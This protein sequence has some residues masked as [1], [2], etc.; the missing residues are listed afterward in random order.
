M[1]GSLQPDVVYV[2][3]GSPGTFDQNTPPPT[4]GTIDTLTVS[5]NFVFDGVGLAGNYTKNSGNITLLNGAGSGGGTFDNQGGITGS[6]DVVADTLDNSGAIDITGPVQAGT[7]DNHGQITT[8]GTANDVSASYELTNTGGINSGGAIQAAT[9]LISSGSLEASLDISAGSATLTGGSVQARDFFA[10]QATIESGNVTIKNW[11]SAATLD[12]VSGSIDSAG[13]L[14]ADA[15][16]MSASASAQDFFVSN[17]IMDG[18]LSATDG[19]DFQSGAIGGK[20]AITSG[21]RTQNAYVILADTGGSVDVTGQVNTGGVSIVV[22]GTLS[23][24]GDVSTTSTIYVG[25]I[26]A[27]TI[28]LQSGGSIS[29]GTVLFGSFGEPGTGIVDG[30][31]WSNS[32]FAGIGG[33]QGTGQGLLTVEN[34]GTF[35]TGNLGIGSYQDQ[36]GVTVNGTGALLET[37]ETG[38]AALAVNDGTLLIES[39][40]SVAS[41]NAVFD[42]SSG[43]VDSTGTLT[44]PASSWNVSG[45]LTIGKAAQGTLLVADGAALHVS[46]SIDV[47]SGSGATGTLQLSG[48]Q[49]TLDVAD[50]LIVGD[51]GA[52]ALE[53]VDGASYTVPAEIIAGNQAGGTGTMTLD[54]NSR[55]TADG[56]LVLGQDGTGFMTVSAG[57]ALVV[58]GNLE[59]GAGKGSGTLTASADD[60]HVHGDLTIN[61]GQMTVVRGNPLTVDGAIELGKNTGSNGTLTLQQNAEV[62]A[63]QDDVTIGSQGTGTLAVDAGASFDGSIN[64]IYLGEQNGATGI[65]T[66]SGAGA[67][68][69]AASLTVGGSGTGSLTVSQGGTVSVAAD[70]TIGEAGTG[71]VTI[72]DS[73]S[74]LDAASIDVGGTG[75]GV[76]LLTGADASVSANLSVGADS[77]GK[78]TATLSSASL[79]T[80]GTLSIGESGN[81]LATIQLASTL[82]ADAIELGVQFGGKGELDASGAGTSVQSHDLTIGSG[83]KGVL[84]LTQGAS[85]TTTGDATVADQ[86][87]GVGSGVSLDTQGSWNLVGDL[88]VGGTGIG[89]VSIKGAASLA[90]SGGVTIGDQAG[91]GGVIALSGTLD[92][93]GS[94]LQSAL[95]FGS[96]L[97]VGNAGDGTLTLASGAL[98]A[99]SPG[100]KGEIDVAAQ[101]G[102][103][104]NLTVEGAGS[105]LRSKSLELGGTATAAGGKARL[106][107]A[108]GATVQ[109]SD[110]HAWKGAAMTLLGGTLMTDP[111]TLDAGSTLEGNGT[112]GG[113][114]LDNGGITA[115]GGAL[116]LTGDIS[117]TGTL[118]INSGASLQLDG[119]IAAGIV[120]NFTGFGG[121]LDLGSSAVL[122]DVMSDFGSDDTIVANASITGETFGAG[123]L[124]L[125]LANGNDL[126]LAGSYTPSETV[127]SGET[128][129]IPCFLD[130]T[131]IAT[132][133]GDVQVERLRPGARVRTASGALRSVRWIGISPVDSTRQ[134]EPHRVWPVRVRAGAFGPGLP[135]RDLLLSPDHS[136]FVEGVLIPIKYLANGTSV[137]QE[138]REHVTYYHVE[139]DSHDVLLAEGL[140]AESYLDTGNRA[141]FANGGAH[142]QLHPDF[143]PLSWEQACAPLCIAGPPMDSVRR[144]LRA[145]LHE[146]GSAAP[147]NSHTPCRPPF[148]RGVTA[149]RRQR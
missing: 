2:N 51:A 100:G 69:D 84:K 95:Y 91:A 56:N 136:L 149:R 112:V 18:T 109:V 61:T 13:E 144:Q 14:S 22:G 117:G 147:A 17:F 44:G 75:T 127:I 132:E 40:G 134:P 99:S 57:A 21:S 23:I 125:T 11:F 83:G 143:A 48:A 98:V 97:V 66:V 6:G 60:M 73:G 119:T 42:S 79:D 8:Q 89:G 67:A 138:R 47:A 58:Y 103:T 74:S 38:A 55:L 43:T 70:L 148:S 90:A 106:S 12:F 10:L 93:S 113:A 34:D 111:V 88:T 76:L 53:L 62:V 118:A 102:S 120:L 68:L 115:D 31:N 24:E 87:Q 116:L 80:K 71:D 137:A 41:G 4:S 39:G 50:A 124:T 101:A 52:G 94:V 121:T 126:V 130:G 35:S 114:I 25:D 129:T 85:L 49:G 29:S 108:D 1:T 78:G 27:G 146:A 145:R 19:G 107:V 133:H 142:R 96:A 65:V 16:S 81:G 139:L 104:G 82:A 3:I 33:A 59:L 26:G 5:S 105:L 46:G 141:A 28:T 122:N 30:G 131:R 128:V 9:T 86:L 77:G 7:I 32:G 72:T 110:L 92:Q 15:G 54:A 20:L 135:K 140:P 45:N 64:T 123:V 36:G 63:G 37:T